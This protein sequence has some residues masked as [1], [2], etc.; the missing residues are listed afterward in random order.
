MSDH[1]RSDGRGTRPHAAGRGAVPLSGTLADFAEML[2]SLPDADST[3]ASS[4]RDGPPPV[5]AGGIADTFAILPDA[6]PGRAVAPAAK[7]PSSSPSRAGQRMPPPSID[8]KPIRTAP[9]APVHPAGA[10][11]LPPEVEEVLFANAAPPRVTSS[12]EPVAVPFNTRNQ[13]SAGNAKEPAR[14]AARGRTTATDRQTNTDEPAEETS[15]RSITRQILDLLEQNGLAGNSQLRIEVHNGV[16]VVAGEVPTPY[17]K[18]LVAHLCRQ[19]SGVEKFVDSMVVREVRSASEVRNA[20]PSRRAVRQPIEWRLPFRAW[21]VG[22]VAG[23]VLAA[24]AIFSLG[25]GQGGPKRLAV[26]PLTGTLVFE[27]KPAA[28]A[29]IVLHPQDPSLSARPRAIVDPDGS[30]AVTTYAPSDGAPAGK[31]KVTIEWRRPI[32]G[33]ESGEGNDA[34]PANVLPVKY[35]SPKTTPVRIKVVEGDNEFPAITF[36]N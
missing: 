11:E 28:G 3:A 35:A 18:Q 14:G 23:L 34:P 26:Y 30:F 5:T 27:G 33:Q 17:E 8:R 25:F 10:N 1:K 31:Y 2:A 13:S 6:D 12:R 29:A 21:H 22:A 15:G 20:R 19:V 7:R 4:E 24:W 32:A 9:P 36:R 16:V